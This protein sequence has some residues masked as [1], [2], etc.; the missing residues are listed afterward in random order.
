MSDDT[1]IAADEDED[2]LDI[3]PSRPEQAANLFRDV[4]FKSVGE[5]DTGAYWVWP[6]AADP[7]TV[8]TAGDAVD[9]LGVGRALQGPAG[10][11]TTGWAGASIQVDPDQP[12]IVE[13]GATYKG[14]IRTHIPAAFVGR[15]RVSVTGVPVAGAAVALGSFEGTDY[16]AAA[17]GAEDVEDVAIRFDIPPGNIVTPALKCVLFEVEHLPSATLAN[18]IDKPLSWAR[19]ALLR[20]I[21]PTEMG[22][23]DGADLS[24]DVQAALDAADAAGIRDALGLELGVDIYSKSATDT[25]LAG[26]QA[27]DA[28]LSAWAT[29]N[30][31]GLL[32]QTGADTFVARSL[33]A[34]AAGFTIT[35]PAGA[36]GNPTFV[37][38][39]DLGALE[40]LGSTGLA[41]RSAADTWV[42]R[43]VAVTAP[44]TVSN[45]DGVSGNPTVALDLTATVAWTGTY[46]FTHTTSG[47]A[48]VTL[49]STNATAGVGG[50]ILSLDRN[51]ASPAA[52]DV[53]G[54]LRYR[55]NDSGGN[56]TVFASI[57]A[58]VLDPTD[59]SEDGLL[60]VF[61]IIAGTSAA[62]LLIGNGVYYSGGADMG[63]NTINTTAY[64]SAG[65]V[66][67]DSDR[68]IRLRSYTVGTL[69]AAGTAG[70]QVYCSNE[71][72]G[73]VPVFDDGTNWRRVTDRAIAA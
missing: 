42:Q 37:L 8:A 1:W 15:A 22:K 2:T 33:S 60:Q 56:S 31:N 26:K 57:L 53:L 46:T 30:S 44:I 70:R 9:A 43:S 20:V 45:G 47:T 71:T 17:A 23:S 10:D 55:G 7:W 24:A 35:N 14:R 32:V 36:A 64:Y 72:G 16:R 73:A 5:E 3:R 59:G 19:P 4:T 25:L 34:P 11:G 6:A 41:V 29:F 38:A 40:G 18:P 52:S 54:Q 49:V 67:I 12:L 58:S 39:N 61:T 28:T 68:I 27:S 63:A 51:R 13:P 21:K 50:P 48:P 69:P 66:V 62:R 65:N